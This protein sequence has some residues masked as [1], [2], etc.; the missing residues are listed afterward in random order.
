[1]I[2]P[3]SPFPSY[4]RITISQHQIGGTPRREHNSRDHAAF[5]RKRRR[6]GEVRKLNARFVV[7]GDLQISKESKSTYSPVVDLSP[8]GRLFIPMVNRRQKSV[9]INLNTAFVQSNLPK[10]INPELPPG[11]L[12]IDEDRMYQVGK[13]RHEDVGVAKLG[14]NYLSAALVGTRRRQG[15]KARVQ[16]SQLCACQETWLRPEPRQLLPLF[17]EQSCFR[18]LRG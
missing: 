16:L 4:L 7:H 6:D 1:M 9:T 12:V 10:P 3:G 8:V 2:R 13:S 11:Y 18:F 14:Y 15:C 17:L 5:K